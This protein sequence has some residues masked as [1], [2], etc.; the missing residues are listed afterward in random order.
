MARKKMSEAKIGKYI[1]ENSPSWGRKLSEATKQKLR[2]ANLGRV[3]SDEQRKKI[4]ERLTGKPTWNKGK[5]MSKEY[6]EKLKGFKSA[7]KKAV[8]C[9]E[10]NVEYESIS[11][12]AKLTGIG[13]K[14]I[15]CAL[16]GGEKF[17]AGGF[18]W[19]YKVDP[20]KFIPGRRIIC[21]ETGV[22][23]NSIVEA[24]R[25]TGIKESNLSM[26]LRSKGRAGG[27]HWNYKT[28]D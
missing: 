1:G 6:C 19:N 5:K 16:R 17:T 18:H 2:E 9:V 3:M 12:A 26:A 27:F 23:Y 22:E 4:S 28:E 10:T 15:S 25:L 13:M 20:K 8:I 24:S 11:E 21:V 7:S 14:N